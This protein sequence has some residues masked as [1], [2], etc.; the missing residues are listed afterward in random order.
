MFS[1]SAAIGIS[2]T[3]LGILISPVVA[4]LIGRPDAVAAIAALMPVVAIQA[5][6][7]VP[8][9]LLQRRMQFKGPALVALFATA[10]YVA[11]QVLL[12]LAG[13]GYWS[14]IIGQVVM[15]TI[16]SYGNFALS[17]WTPSLGDPRAA[18]RQEGRYSAGVFAN[19]SLQYFNKNADYWYVGAQLGAAPLGTY[20][21]SFVV[22]SILRLRVSYTVQAI[23][24]PVFSRLSEAI[25]RTQEVYVRAVWVQA[26]A[27]LPALAGLIV[28]APEVVEVFFGTQWSQA[29][30]PLRWIAL[31]AA[32]DLLATAQ[33]AAAYAHG[34]MRRLVSVSAVRGASLALGL[35]MI[36][37]AGPTLALV[38]VVVAISSCIALIVSQFLIANRL[39]LGIG[40][41]GRAVLV[42]TASAVVMALVVALVRDMLAEKSLGALTILVLSSTIGVGTYAAIGLVTWRSQFIAS[43]QD[44]SSVLLP[45]SAVTGCRRLLRRL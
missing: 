30:P 42:P 17:G 27:V 1:L 39:N 34:L 18:W 15:M 45:K 20:Y 37:M 36:T 10:V 9:G 21:I 33:V 26:A 5:L 35:V 4:R 44:I 25:G 6:G 24:F 31:G 29:V 3:I 2:L 41:A 38:G 13:A 22:P 40:L 12:A 11:T 8:S 28:L 7:I 16:I 14:V 32:F 23:L 43:M 19:E